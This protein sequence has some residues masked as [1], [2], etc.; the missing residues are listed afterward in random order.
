MI[1]L[2]RSTFHCL[3]LQDIVTKSEK[4]YLSSSEPNEEVFL[5]FNENDEKI[6][7]RKSISSEETTCLGSVY[8]QVRY[9]PDGYYGDMP[10]PNTLVKI[11]NKFDISSLLEGAYRINGLPLDQ[12]YTIT[13]SNRKFKT[14][15]TT[16]TLTKEKPNAE[17]YLFYYSYDERFDRYDT[18]PAI[19]NHKILC[20]CVT[21]NH[22]TLIKTC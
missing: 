2:I 7:N 8:G 18:C 11:G 10:A 22:C 20:D 9:S 15:T 12:T 1:D 16:I 14:K 4:V 3:N 6:R 17:V 21:S 13:Y 5:M 19:F